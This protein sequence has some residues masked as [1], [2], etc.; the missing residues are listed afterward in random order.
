MNVVVSLEMTPGPSICSRTH[1]T[2]TPVAAITARI[3]RGTEAE[4]RTILN[5]SKFLEPERW[6][7]HLLVLNACEKNWTR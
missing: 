2:L 4:P 3:M 1:P 6:T 5:V 7:L